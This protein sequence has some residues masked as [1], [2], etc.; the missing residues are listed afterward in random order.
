MGLAIISC[1]KVKD[2]EESITN[3]NKKY[4]KSNSKNKNKGKL[5]KDINT[6][7]INSNS[8]NL[9]KKPKT[10]KLIVSNIL[11][12]KK[13]KSNKSFNYQKPNSNNKPKNQNNSQNNNK[14]IKKKLKII[15]VIIFFPVHQ[16]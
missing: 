4:Y 11:L 9:S 6:C 1:F 7:I 2:L 13:Y 14:E 3:D 8:N 16:K 15:L 12:P 5:N 10:L